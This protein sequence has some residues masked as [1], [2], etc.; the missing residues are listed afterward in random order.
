[1]WWRGLPTSTSV[2]VSRAFPTGVEVRGR[3]QISQSSYQL[4]SSCKIAFSTCLSH[5]S[6][7]APSQNFICFAWEEASWAKMV[8]FPDHHDPVDCHWDQLKIFSNIITISL[9]AGWTSR[10]KGS[11][12][13]LQNGESEGFFSNISF[14]KR[15]AKTVA[16]EITQAIY[17]TLGAFTGKFLF[18]V[19]DCSLHW[20]HQIFAVAH[21]SNPIQIYWRALS[22]SEAS[23]LGQPRH[24]FAPGLTLE[25]WAW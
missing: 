21:I 15:W 10:T 22:S 16:G 13:L 9:N 11:R 25:Q 20:V 19:L 7:Q 2:A 12:L 1:M 4:K 17:T 18:N 3:W 14:N 24:C 8:V 6:L 5:L 23:W